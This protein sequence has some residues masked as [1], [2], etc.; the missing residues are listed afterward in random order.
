[1]TLLEDDGLPVVLPPASSVRFIENPFNHYFWCHAS[2]SG[3]EVSS[4]ELDTKPFSIR[5]QGNYKK[6]CKRTEVSVANFLDQS[7]NRTSKKRREPSFGLDKLQRYINEAE[8]L[9]ITGKS[10][11]RLGIKEIENCNS[12]PEKLKIMKKNEPSLDLE[13]V[14]SDL[15]EP[16][17]FIDELNSLNVLEDTESCFRSEKH[18]T[19][20]SDQVNPIAVDPSSDLNRISDGKYR[21]RKK[22]AIPFGGTS[23]IESRKQKVQVTEPVIEPKNVANYELGTGGIDETPKK[24][25]GSSQRASESRCL[26]GKCVSTSNKLTSMNEETGSIERNEKATNKCRAGDVTEVDK[27]D[28]AGKGEKVKNSELRKKA[29]ICEKKLKKSIKPSQGNIRSNC[30]EYQEMQH[31][32]KTTCGRKSVEVSGMCH[33]NQEKEAIGDFDH[34]NGMQNKPEAQHSGRYGVE[35]DTDASVVKVPNSKLK[36]ETAIYDKKF[37]KGTN[38]SPDATL[39]NYDQNQNIDCGVKVSTERK[40]G[41]ASTLCIENQENENLSTKDSLGLR[42]VMQNM[43]GVQQSGGCCVKIGDISIRFGEKV[44]N[45]PDDM[46]QTINCKEEIS[47]IREEIRDLTDQFSMNRTMVR[48]VEKMSEVPA[49]EVTKLNEELMNELKKALIEANDIEAIAKQWKC[50]YM[51][52]ENKMKQLERDGTLRK[53][54]YG[55]LVVEK[56]NLEAVLGTTN[57][58][59]ANSQKEL[60]KRNAEILCGEEKLKL[61]ENLLKEKEQAIEEMVKFDAEERNNVSDN[62]ELG[63][64]DS[65]E[66]TDERNILRSVSSSLSCLSGLV[67]RRRSRKEVSKKKTMKLIIDELDDEIVEL[68]KKLSSE[69]KNCAL[70]N[71]FKEERA[72]ELEMYKDKVTAD[73]AMLQNV[74]K[75][76]DIV[77]SNLEKEQ[78]HYGKLV[79]KLTKEK[80]VLSQQNEDLSEE[81][82][83]LKEELRKAAWS[84]KFASSFNAEMEEKMQKYVSL[85]K[86]KAEEE[87]RKSQETLKLMS[88]ESEKKDKQLRGLNAELIAERK[89]KQHLKEKLEQNVKELRANQGSRKSTAVK[90]KEHLVPNIGSLVESI[91]GDFTAILS[92]YG[93]GGASE[94]KLMQ[95]VCELGSQLSK[96]ISGQGG[97][98]DGAGKDAL[99][100][101]TSDERKADMDMHKGKCHCHDEL[102]LFESKFGKLEH[103]IKVMREQ[104]GTL[105]GKDSILKHNEMEA[106]MEVEILRKENARMIA[107]LCKVNKLANDNGAVLDLDNG[108]MIE[109][110]Q[111]IKLKRAMAEALTPVDSSKDENQRPRK[112]ISKSLKEPHAL[113]DNMKQF[114]EGR[115]LKQQ[116]DSRLVEDLTWN[117]SGNEFKNEQGHLRERFRNLAPS[118]DDKRNIDHETGYD[119]LLDSKIHML[120]TEGLFHPKEELVEK[121]SDCGI[122]GHSEEIE[123]LRMDLGCFDERHTAASSTLANA[124]STK[125][126][127]ERLVNE[128]TFELNELIVAR[129]QSMEELDKCSS[130]LNSTIEEFNNLL[131]R[132]E[133]LEV[134]EKESQEKPL[135]NNALEKYRDIMR[136]RGNIVSLKEKLEEERA[137]NDKIFRTKEEELR[138][139]IEEIKELREKLVD[140][141]KMSKNANGSAQAIKSDVKKDF[142]DREEFER[143]LKNANLKLEKLRA[144]SSGYQIRPY[145]QEAR[146]EEILNEM[147][148]L[149]KEKRELGVLISQYKLSLDN[150]DKNNEQQ[151]KKSQERMEHMI[152]SSEDEKKSAKVKVPAITDENNAPHLG[153]K[154]LVVDKVFMG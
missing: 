147:V 127:A 117:R 79:Q 47:G 151:I 90:W 135:N 22:H 46:V 95:A 63:K 8:N 88:F 89:E 123:K 68:G 129:E 20:N 142:Y 7:A 55:N 77:N 37:T 1:M 50:K 13:N 70:L 105:V 19:C 75:E 71:I 28:T 114:T 148:H 34:T 15:S 45:K 144:E 56:E 36:E 98:R 52:I 133:E 82:I 18:Q 60:D 57:E 35:K 26:G 102:S 31:A 32:K 10:K 24:Y 42:D 66:L 152:P 145:R 137:G 48:E 140:V 149:E 128:K 30:A 76:L 92:D 113:E 61:L 27:N 16:Q 97:S 132:K 134:K 40:T 103:E 41:E 104:Y 9:K 143:C 154:T 43:P 141:N 62:I 110:Y 25:T 116:C 115:G 23:Q 53:A 12:E 130:E 96:I 38:C 78:R 14:E 81:L 131:V 64:G 33:G 84:L 153:V 126:E 138:K 58:K 21:P 11:P 69:R 150:L 94:L 111:N 139:R 2:L 121:C 112:G 44:I 73:A 6:L 5:K 100:T 109:K 65:C 83:A 49:G 67:K 122:T 136:L 108:Y 124:L 120:K 59:L 86:Q 51:E 4:H 74:Q 101:R 146:L 80:G 125:I 54:Q 106:K 72:R 87:R 93:C 107:E 99:G 17:S 118:L 91:M 3:L 39:S 29:A 119:R 85:I